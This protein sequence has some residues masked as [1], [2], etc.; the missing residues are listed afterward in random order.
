MS[1]VQ[2]AAFAEIKSLAAPLRL[3]VTADDEGFP[4][5]AG[6]L[7]QIEWTGGPDLAVW[8]DRRRLFERLWAIPGVRRH[9]T[10]DREMRA[11]VP[12]ETLEQVAR[13]IR[14]RVR[15]RGG[16]S[17]EVM[18]RARASRSARWTVARV[19]LRATSEVRNS[20]AGEA[21]GIEVESLA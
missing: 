1:A 12:P 20:D 15:R 2:R 21:P 19:L 14:A 17:P 16:A 13:L 9:Q 18:A 3:R 8:T 7:G 5:I 4:V 6:R 10:G 11:L